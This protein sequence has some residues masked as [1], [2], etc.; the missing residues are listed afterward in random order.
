V[1]RTGWLTPDR[2]ADWWNANRTTARTGDVTRE[3]ADDSTSVVL[4]RAGVSQDAQ[5]VRLLIPS[6]RGGE[7]ASAGGE[8]AEADLILLGTSAFDVQRA[9]R[10]E[11]SS[12]WYEVVYVAPEQPSSGERVEAHCRQMQ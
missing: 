2:A 3:I 5:T 6:S 7:S 8:Q 10:F 9:D 11:V 1:G 4:V 12:E